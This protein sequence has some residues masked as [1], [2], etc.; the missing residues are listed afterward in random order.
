MIL[1]D[2]RE[3]SKRV[4][5]VDYDDA[6]WLT[7]MLVRAHQ[8][9]CR[10]CARYAR[11]IALLTQALREVSERSVDREKLA[12]LKERTIARLAG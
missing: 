3:V 1:F 10:H 4:S 9:M 2:C 12:G 11:Q 6:S 8:A 7:R 5:R